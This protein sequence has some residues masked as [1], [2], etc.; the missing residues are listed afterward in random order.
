MPTTRNAP[1][2]CPCEANSG[3]FRPGNRFAAC[4]PE[5]LLPLVFL[6]LLGQCFGQH[7]LRVRGNV[8][9]AALLGDPPTLQNG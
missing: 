8:A 3:Y 2:I 7:R 5:C 1:A 6:E 9:E 4:G